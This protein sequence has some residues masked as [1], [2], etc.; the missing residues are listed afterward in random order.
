VR[1]GWLGSQRN[2]ASNPPSR[3]SASR[4]V[5]GW[6]DAQRYALADLLTQVH[7]DLVAG[8]LAA[9]DA[10]Q[11]EIFL[12]DGQTLGFEALVI[13][14]GARPVA[15]MQNATTWWPGGDPNTFG[16]LLRDLEEGYTKRVAFVI[17]PGGV[18]PLPL[19]ELA[20]ITARGASGM[21]IDDAQ[22]MV[23]TPL[24]E[25]LKLRGVPMTGATPRAMGAAAVAAPSEQAWRWASASRC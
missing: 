13:A 12:A 6:L 21:D 18:W 4:S 16:G 20:L 8:E 7:G 24:S 15:R 25:E 3:R 2:T 17:P 23:I 14:I 9:I 5:T 11:R 10:P 19:Y 1:P 22:F